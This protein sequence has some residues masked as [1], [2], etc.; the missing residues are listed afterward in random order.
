VQES[1]RNDKKVTGC[2]ISKMPSGRRY[3][4]AWRLI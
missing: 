4:K 2:K 1:K 3:E